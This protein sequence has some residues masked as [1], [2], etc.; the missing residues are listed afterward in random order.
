MRR[1]DGEEGGGRGEKEEDGW[2]IIERARKEGD[3]G[4][5]KKM[6]ERVWGEKE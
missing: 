5:E 4:K 6:K 3:G 1:G 2:G